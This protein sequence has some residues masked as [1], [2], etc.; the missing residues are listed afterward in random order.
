MAKL[1][2][3]EAARLVGV[4]HNAP[5]RH[6]PDRESLLAALAAEGFAA[7]GRALQEAAASGGLRAMGEA[8]V[9]FALERPQR[10]RLM[11]GGAVPI[12]PHAAL[13][14]NATRVFES[15]AQALAPQL[16]GAAGRDASIAA[17]A[18]VHGLA[19][20]LLDERIAS[21]A[22][23]GRDRADL[24]RAVLGSIRFA[25]AKPQSPP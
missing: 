5:Y 17:W 12:A 2:L 20:L 4:S 14:E 6:F 15:L 7:L 24:V 13:R 9:R 23:R 8:Y 22:L 25:A 19:Q 16:P 3:R 1:S 21:A 10:F 18:L 11:F